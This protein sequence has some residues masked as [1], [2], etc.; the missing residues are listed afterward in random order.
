M[1]NEIEVIQKLENKI[2]TAKESNLFPLAQAHRKELRELRDAHIGNLKKRVAVIKDAKKQEYLKKYEQDGKD[3]RAELVIETQELNAEAEQKLLELKEIYDRMKAK[4]EELEEIYGSCAS[5]R[6]D[7]YGLEDSLSFKHRALNLILE[8]NNNFNKRYL[9]RKF[10][11]QYNEVF[12]AATDEL[13][14]YDKVFEEALVF[15][16]LETV[17]DIYY[18]LTKADD[19]LQKLSEVEI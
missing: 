8:V 4:E 2:Q 11:D 10:N 14:R 17:R 3:K 7:V 6:S 16:D 5:I 15:G 18:T 19:F 9:E 1:G 13:D 12:K